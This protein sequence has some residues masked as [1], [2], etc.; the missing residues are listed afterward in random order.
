MELQHWELSKFKP[1]QNNPRRND[2]V[3]DKMVKSIAE[4]GF[5]MPVVVK[6]DGT[7]VDGHLRLKAAQQIGMAQVPVVLADELN[8][9]QVKAFRLLANRSANWAEWDTE[10]LAME[11]TELDLGDFDL[12]LTGFDDTEL[13]LLLLEDTEEKPQTEY[14]SPQIFNRPDAT[15][16]NRYTY[17]DRQEEEEPEEED[18]EPEKPTA[19][20][21]QYPLAIVL[22]FAD[23]QRWK[24]YKEAIGIKRDVP[25]FLNL[26]NSVD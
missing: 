15:D 12:D 3:V 2:E 14:Q 25:A 22:P 1:Y 5:R 18:E 16:Y 6:S 10:L 13:D 23:Y 11:L 17:G 20:G 7:V 19:I 24:A 26:L 8:D 9:Q 4:Y 21:G